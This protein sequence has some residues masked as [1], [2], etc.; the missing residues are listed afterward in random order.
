MQNKNSPNA[1]ALGHTHTLKFSAT[2]RK[3]SQIL[4]GRLASK[5]PRKSLAFT[6]NI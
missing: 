1:R 6:V 3:S 5:A 4:E 2:G